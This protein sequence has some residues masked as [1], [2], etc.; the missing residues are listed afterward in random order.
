[1]ETAVEIEG[2]AEGFAATR[3]S[4]T[5]NIYTD[6][7]ELHIASLGSNATVEQINLLIKG[8]RIGWQRGVKY[9]HEQKAYE[10]RAMLG[11]APHD[12]KEIVNPT[13]DY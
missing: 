12:I 13:N 11:L 3:T 6:D 8:Y 2:V 4:H 10:I 1:M 7:F 5:V 9:G